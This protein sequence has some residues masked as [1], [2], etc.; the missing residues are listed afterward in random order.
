MFQKKNECKVL[1]EMKLY[2]L[3]S[4]F[5]W[6]DRDCWEGN[7]RTTLG[8]PYIPAKQILLHPWPTILKYNPQ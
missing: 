7:A 6:F 1:A 3:D 8:K 5:K 4:I 2:Q